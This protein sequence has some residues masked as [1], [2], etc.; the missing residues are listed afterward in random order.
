MRTYL[1]NRTLTGLRLTTTAAILACL[2]GISAA[3]QPNQTQPV[4]F[5]L[6]GTKRIACLGDSITQVGDGPG[7]YVWLLRHYLNDLYPQQGIEVINAGISGNKSTDMIARF[8]TDILDKKPDLLTISV[9][10]NDVWHGFYDNHPLGDGPR[11][12]SLEDYRKNVDSMI[13]SAQSSAIRVVILSG[14]MIHEDPKDPMNIKAERYNAALRDL[15]R[16]Y[17]LPFVDYQK[18]FRAVIATYRED[19]GG[20]DNFLTV[21]GVH[22]NAEGNKIMAHT[23]LTTLGIS[24]EAQATVD[25]QVVKEEKG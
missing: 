21:D 5:A 9:G 23:L 18:V 8:K 15:A 10:V 4:P 13:R 16:Q 12:V 14:T 20:R 2:T 25:V 3:S 1:W 22:M 6:Q 24:P 7:G 11:G 17:H 19:S